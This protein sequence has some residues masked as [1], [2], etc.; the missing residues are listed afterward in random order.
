LESAVFVEA[1]RQPVRNL[2]GLH[3]SLARQEE[4]HATGDLDA[5]FAADEA[6]HIE[7]FALS[8]YGGAWQVVQRTKLQLDRLR[9]LSLP[10][11]STLRTLIDDHRAIVNALA[12][13]M[14]IEG[15]EFVRTH[16]RRVLDHLPTL[17]H[18]HPDY[19]GI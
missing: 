18:R 7:I 3:E 6:L 12:E 17:E 14:P 1:C 13:R 9:R 19:F 10:E 5:F 15:Q 11:P 8:G 2:T 4:A 16:A